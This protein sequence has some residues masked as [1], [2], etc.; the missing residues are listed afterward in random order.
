MAKQT[1]LRELLDAYADAADMHGNLRAQMKAAGITQSEEVGKAYDRVQQTRQNIFL[2]FDRINNDA[3]SARKIADSALRSA[4]VM[5]AELVATKDAKRGPQYKLF[6]E[7]MARD[8]VPIE[9]LFDD[10]WT[11][12]TFVGVGK[13]GSVVAECEAAY[14][15]LS[16]WMRDAVRMVIAPKTETIYINLNQRPNGERDAFIYAS[17]IEAE[18]TNPTQNGIKRIATAIPVTFTVAD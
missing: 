4:E 6:D 12:A 9:V 15:F 13:D 8:G 18:R 17:A 7:K 5:I 16:Y 10:C 3:V 1:Q 14:A 2:L 11:N